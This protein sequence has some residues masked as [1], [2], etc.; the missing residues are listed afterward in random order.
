MNRVDLSFI[1]ETCAK[2]FEIR[3][4]AWAI[5]YGSNTHPSAAANEYQSTFIENFL[6]RL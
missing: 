6:R 1:P 4:K 2:A 3:D 5:K